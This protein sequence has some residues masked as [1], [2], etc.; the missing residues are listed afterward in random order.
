M[1]LR[2]GRRVTAADLSYNGDGITL[3]DTPTVPSGE[4]W[5]DW[6]STIVIADPGTK[7]GVWGWG[8]GH[9]FGP[10]GVTDAFAAM[11]IGISTDGG[12]N[13]SNGVGP[14]G[15]FSEEAGERRAVLACHHFVTATPTGDIVVRAQ[16]QAQTTSAQFFNGSFMIQVAPIP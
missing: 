14:R 10:T 11:R 12:V 8:D 15:N 9:A 6:G 7:V 3:P 16:L 5:G 13:F 1:V 4:A 2:A